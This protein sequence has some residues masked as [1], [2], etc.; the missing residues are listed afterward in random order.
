VDYQQLL[1]LLALLNGKAGG[2]ISGADLSRV[3]D[4][5]LGI[6]TNTYNTQQD[7]GPNLTD[8]SY[9]YRPTWE[10]LLNEE[11]YDENSIEMQIASS[12][13]SGVPLM[14]LKKQIPQFLANL[15]Q[16]SGPNDSTTQEYIAYATKLDNENRDYNVALT[17]ANTDKSSNTWW[18]KSGIRDPSLQADPAQILNPQ[19]ENMMR[20]YA[21]I[22]NS[23]KTGGYMGSGGR[24]IQGGEQPNAKQE[25]VD[26]TRIQSDAKN[27][28]ETFLANRPFWQQR[29]NEKGKQAEQMYVQRKVSE[30][31]NTEDGRERDRMITRGSAMAG[32][33]K[34]SGSSIPVRTAKLNKEAEEEMLKVASLLQERA[35]RL[36]SK[37]PTPAQQDVMNRVMSLAMA[38]KL[39]K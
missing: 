31:T 5:I 26:K 28:A 25:A 7:T 22:A 3:E 13:T 16:P 35:T 24:Y 36:A 2:Q 33:L 39:K 1:Q 9:Q 27:A 14:E 11:Y 34:N 18:A 12:I 21:P 6:L 4:P 29:T 38:E 23:G 19:L 10:S 8:L 32:R 20:M 30:A 17:K 15:G 37:M